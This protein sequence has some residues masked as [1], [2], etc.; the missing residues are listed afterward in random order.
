MYF[1]RPVGKRRSAIEQC[2]CK[3]GREEKKQH[4]NDSC[5]DDIL[6]LA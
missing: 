4:L 6:T 2:L 5:I 1:N 3:K